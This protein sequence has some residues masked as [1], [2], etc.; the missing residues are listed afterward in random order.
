MRLYQL[1][2]IFEAF[3]RRWIARIQH[4]QFGTKI[5]YEVTLV[6][7]ETLEDPRLRRY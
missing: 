7:Q 4:P 5:P 3:R 2:I 6:E 1:F